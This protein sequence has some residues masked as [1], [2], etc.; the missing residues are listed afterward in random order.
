MSA[1]KKTAAEVASASIDSESETG[2]VVPPPVPPTKPA[3]IKKVPIE[4]G[5]K[6]KRRWHPGTVAGREVIREMK[7]KKR[8][9]RKAPFIR[10]VRDIAEKYQISD[11]SSVRFTATALEVLQE[12][13]EKLA[14]QLF[15]TTNN[16]AHHRR[17]KATDNPTITVQDMTAAID[18][19]V[20]MAQYAKTM[21]RASE[22][23]KKQ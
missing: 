20:E 8:A 4:G 9:I 23:E 18:D 6:K 14:V 1:T 22:K 19:A 3:K 10:L 12:D 15:R 13:L 11:D 5:I 16:R 2:L 21:S 17:G 7:S